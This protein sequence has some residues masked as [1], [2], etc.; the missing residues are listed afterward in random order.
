MSIL[1]NN[2]I[3]SIGK[4]SNYNVVPD[5]RQQIIKLV[6]GN[7]VLD[8]WNGARQ[9]TGDIVSL[10]ATFSKADGDS[11]ISLWNNRT[12]VPV[13]LENGEII[14]EARIVIKRISYHDFLPFRRKFVDLDI[15][16]WKI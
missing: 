1:I 10:T 14:Y 6:N 15:E 16:I 12:H 8:G 13:Q 5:D 9:T 3:R 11:V 4:T 2:S 7:T